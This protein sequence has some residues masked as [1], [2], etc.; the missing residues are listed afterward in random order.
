MKKLKLNISDF[1]GVEILDRVQLKKVMGGL[2]SEDDPEGGDCGE[3]ECSE[4]A[5]CKNENFPNCKLVTCESTKKPANYCYCP[6]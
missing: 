6:S 1:A 5:D 2:G 4:D 3:S